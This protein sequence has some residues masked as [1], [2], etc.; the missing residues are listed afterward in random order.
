MAITSELIGNLNTPGFGFKNESAVTY[1][2]PKYSN[3]ITILTVIWSGRNYISYDIIDRET[4]NVVGETRVSSSSTWEN[5]TDTTVVEA[6][7]KGA[8]IRF[9]NSNPLQV[10]IVPN[11]RQTPPVW[12]G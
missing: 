9:N 1:A 8:L 11:P 5:Y 10:Y 6:L 2:L 7:K 12:N 3:G 4:G